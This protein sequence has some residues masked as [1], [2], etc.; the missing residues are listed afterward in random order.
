MKVCN[1]IGSSQSTGS[2]M[3]DESI[4]M[5]LNDP[6]END[7]NYFDTEYALNGE[8][9]NV[10]ANIDEHHL[11]DEDHD[12]ENSNEEEN[13][14][15]PAYVLNGKEDYG[16]VNNDEVDGDGII[17]EDKDGDNTDEKQVVTLI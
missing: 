16:I 3:Q 8:E 1:E 12:E 2:M 17:D 6:K 10:E 14:I 9:E 13:Y 5:H 7:E 11:N 4:G 15:G